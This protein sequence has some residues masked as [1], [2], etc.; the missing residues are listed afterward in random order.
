MS[1]WNWHKNCGCI[2]HG[3]KFKD[4]VIQGLVAGLMEGVSDPENEAPMDH[5]LPVS[6]HLFCS[7]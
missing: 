1:S 2:N 4:K 3:E 7:G 5:F 6:S